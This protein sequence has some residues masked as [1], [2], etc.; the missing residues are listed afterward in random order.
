MG[1]E[2]RIRGGQLEDVG[3]VNLLPLLAAGVTPAAQPPAETDLP[4]AVPSVAPYNAVAP[5]VIPTPDG[6]GSTIH[7]S[8][9]DMGQRWN[10]YRYWMANTPYPGQDEKEENPCIWGSND[11]NTWEVPQGAVNPLYP[12]PAGEG[13]HWADTDLL[14]DPDQKCLVLVF[15]DGGGTCYVV[16]SPDGV[17]WPALASAV[18]IPQ[19]VIPGSPLLLS[20]SLVRIDAYLWRMYFAVGGGAF[21][22]APSPLGPWGNPTTCTGLSGWH[23][24]VILDRDAGEYRA[25]SSGGTAYRSANGI[26]WQTLGGVL[27]NRP[28]WEAGGTLYRACMR[29]YNADSY[30][31]WYGV[32]IDPDPFTGYT[33][34][35]KSLW[36]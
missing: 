1:Y 7:P 4:V 25:I 30:H 9:V 29:P 10:G 20:P 24:H 5:S 19:S 15:N 3:A 31:V 11:A 6:S 14:Y 13:S 22:E 34:I 35:P 36:A 17:Q 2:R 18:T 33:R 21:I 12:A 23:H 16:T 27:P 28:G 32:M 8:A 26:A